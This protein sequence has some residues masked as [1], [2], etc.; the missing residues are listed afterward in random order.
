MINL[1]F[2]ITKYHRLITPNFARKVNPCFS[3]LFPECYSEKQESSQLLVTIPI[4]IPCATCNNK[5]FYFTFMF[6][7]E[8]KSV[9]NTE[10]FSGK[11][12]IL[13]TFFSS[14][15]WKQSNVV[16][17]ETNN[18]DSY[19]PYCDPWVQPHDTYLLKKKVKTEAAT[20]RM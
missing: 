11:K 15:N 18:P 7:W 3:S 16:Q 19:F 4:L 14:P 17:H 13:N 2:Q 8:S 10:F 12:L 6:N 20:K 1:L 5:S 9:L